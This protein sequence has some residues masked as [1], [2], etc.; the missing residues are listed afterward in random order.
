MSATITAAS[1]NSP[2]PRPRLNA[3]FDTFLSLLTAQLRNQDPLKAMDA[4]QMTQQ[5]V[6]FAAVEQQLA[7]N[8]NLERLITLQQGQQL[9]AAAPLIGR[10]VE[11][12]SDRLVLQNGEAR[13]RLPPAAL[14]RS[15]RVEVLD[16]QGRVI[17]TADLRLGE[18]PTDWRWDG[19]DSRGTPRPDGAYALRVTGT[20]ADGTSVPLQPGVL[21]R[22]TAVERREGE[23]RLVMG[24]LALPFDRLRGLAGP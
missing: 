11:V 6:Q 1:G 15:A 20:T 4:Q 14:A 10:M 3:D 5:L 13:L 22:A 8:A 19:R 24:G 17:R 18:A 12:E 23:V 16:A 2:T 21:A 9:V 7:S